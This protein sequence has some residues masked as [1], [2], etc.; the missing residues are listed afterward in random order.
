MFITGL[1]WK[2]L[3]L[4]STGKTLQVSLKLMNTVRIGRLFYDVSLLYQHSNQNPYYP[5]PSH[6]TQGVRNI[7]YLRLFGSMGRIVTEKNTHK[8]DA[9]SVIASFPPTK[10]LSLV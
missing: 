9:I 6:K 7:Q 4:T 5:K 1:V 10:L 2:T 8:F 3:L